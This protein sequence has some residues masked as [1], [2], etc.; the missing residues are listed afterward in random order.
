MLF[1]LIILD[2]TALWQ[3][4]W[5]YIERAGNTQALCHGK[6]IVSLLQDIVYWEAWATCDMLILCTAL[7]VYELA[8]LMTLR[9]ER[10]NVTE[11]SDPFLALFGVK[12]PCDVYI[13][14]SPDFCT[15]NVNA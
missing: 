13:C 4:I 5:A 15:R 8:V 9:H 3:W 11:L 2:N 12:Q 1:L 6:I 10:G 14:S 7:Y